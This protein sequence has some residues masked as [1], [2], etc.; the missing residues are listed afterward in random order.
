MQQCQKS[1]TSEPNLLKLVESLLVN[2][3]FFK[4]NTA[5][6]VKVEQSVHKIPWIV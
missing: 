5:L 1:C 4:S 2:I 3:N 6:S